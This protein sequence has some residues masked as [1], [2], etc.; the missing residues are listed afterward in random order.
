MIRYVNNSLHQRNF[1]SPQKTKPK[2]KKP[3]HNSGLVVP[4]VVY[5]NY[6]SVPKMP[7]PKTYIKKFAKDNRSNPTKA[8]TKFE[9]FL[10]SLNGGAL[11]G[12]FVSQHVFSPKWILDFFFPD[13]RLGIEVDGS[14]HNTVQ[15]I[16]KDKVKD[17]D[18]K[19]FEITLLRVTNAEIFG[20]ANALILKLREAWRCASKRV[21]GNITSCV[22]NQPAHLK[23]N[24]NKKRPTNNLYLILCPSCGHSKKILISGNTTKRSYKCSR[25]SAYGKAELID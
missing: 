4:R 17:R 7:K 12:R 23:F 19:K 11:K 6:G 15:Q 9:E 22:G 24:T 16:K 21:R 1:K 8:E 3:A 25:C 14:I 20:D 18:A 10:N 13:I 5:E 2:K